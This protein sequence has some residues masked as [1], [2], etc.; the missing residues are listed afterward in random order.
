MER[1]QRSRH[2]DR[3]SVTDTRSAGTQRTKQEGRGNE[4]EGGQLRRSRAG[5]P[6]AARSW[7]SARAWMQAAG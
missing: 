7:L 1:R 2:E 6:A 3:K 4:R 5:P